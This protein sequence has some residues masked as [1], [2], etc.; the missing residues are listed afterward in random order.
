MN[1]P[2]MLLVVCIALLTALVVTLTRRSAYPAPIMGFT[3]TMETQLTASGLRVILRP[4]TDQRFAAGLGAT[5]TLETPA[6][7]ISVHRV[8]TQTQVLLLELPYRRAG[9]TPLTVRIGAITLRAAVERQAERIVSPLELNIGARAVRVGDGRAPAAVL[10]PLDANGNVSSQRV[11]IRAERPDGS[12][13]ERVIAAEHL[14]AWTFVS[15]GTRI[16]RLSIAA[17]GMEAANP[18]RA[19]RGEVDVLPAAIVS[20]RFSASPTALSSATRDPLELRL[21]NARDAFGNAGVEGGL[22]E[23]GSARGAWQLFAARPLVR[24]EANLRLTPELPIGEYG[25]TARS[26]R[27]TY[28]ADLQIRSFSTEPWSARLEGR[29]LRVTAPLD[30]LGAWLDDGTPVT[31]LIQTSAV[32]LEQRLPLERGRLEWTLPPLEGKLRSVR[33]S[34]AGQSRLALVVP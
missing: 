8:T 7:P 16:G 34:V 9:I 3:P 10:H 28:R 6:G 4:P 25:L 5:L 21:S 17:S 23:F 12:S 30:A 32:K 29:T 13:F 18:A 27:S 33:V 31:V 14:V 15:P 26:D 20:A 22:V 1:R 2:L 11:L 19:E 24:A